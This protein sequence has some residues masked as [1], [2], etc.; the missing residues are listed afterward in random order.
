MSQP[1][2]A[3]SF[4]GGLFDVSFTTFVTLKFIQVIYGLLVAL[5]LLTGL[6]FFLRLASQVWH[7]LPG[8]RAAAAVG[9]RC[10]VAR[11]SGPPRCRPCRWP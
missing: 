8:V 1:L 11:R 4:F 3:K 2:E 9:A 5:I 10:A 7:R 6:I